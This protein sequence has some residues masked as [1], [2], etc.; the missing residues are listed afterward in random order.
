MIEHLIAFRQWIDFRWITSTSQSSLRWNVESRIEKLIKIFYTKFLRRII[1]FTTWITRMKIEIR[2]L[3]FNFWALIKCVTSNLPM[4]LNNSNL[5]R[6]NLLSLRS[7][8]H[9]SMS[10]PTSQPHV[11]EW[12]RCLQCETF[13]CF[14]KVRLFVYGRWKFWRP[15]GKALSTTLGSVF[16]WFFNRP[17]NTWFYNLMLCTH[18]PLEHMLWALLSQNKLL[19]PQH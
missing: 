10:S 2:F 11:A 12:S 1:C 15:S 3:T 7:H 16:N 17:C 8:F 18:L 14:S 9:H 5:H 4:W 19:V 6:C 13:D